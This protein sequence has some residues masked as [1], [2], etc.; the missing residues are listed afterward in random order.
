MSISQEYSQW[1]VVNKNIEIIKKYCRTRR[2]SRRC[3]YEISNI[4]ERWIISTFN[5]MGTITKSNAVINTKAIDE[6]V[7]KKI[8]YRDQATKILIN[9]F[10]KPLED[11]KINSIE[12]KTKIE[13]DQISF[14]PTNKKYK[15]F[16]IKVSPK[17]IE[18]L[19]QYP[20]LKIIRM[21][22]RY[23]TMIG[24]GQQWSIP[25]A[26]YDYFYNE[27]NARNEGFASPLNS[28]LMGKKD[29]NFCSL[30]KDVD[31]PFGS[32][33][34]FFDTPLRGVW[35]INP[36]FIESLMIATVNHMLNNLEMANQGN[37]ELTIFYI[38][39]SWFDSEAYTKVHESKYTRDEETLLPGQYFYE[40]AK[41]ITAKFK[42][43]AFVLS[44]RDFK[45]KNVWNKMKLIRGGKPKYAYCT[46]VFGGP[47]Y[48]PGAL[49]LAHSI[50][51]TKTKYPIICMVTPDIEK[52]DKQKLA[53]V[54]DRVVEVNYLEFK[55]QQMKTEKQREY[56]GEWSSKAYT[57][58]QCLN[59]PFHKVIFLDSDLIIVNN[60]DHIFDYN[61]PAGVL[62]NPWVQGSKNDF[63]KGLS[64]GKPIPLDK[65][66]KSL[67]NS[68]SPSAHLVLLEPNRD[69]FKKL[70][71]MVKKMSP[72]GFRKSI[73]GLD[74]QSINYLYLIKKKT[75]TFLDYRYNYILW[76]IKKMHYRLN[77]R[78]LPKPF[79]IHFT[80]KP[81]PWEMKREEW[82]DLGIYWQIA[83]DLI[84]RY[85]TLKSAF[86]TE[87]KKTETKCPYCTTIQ[88]MLGEEA[89]V[90]Q[91][92]H[93]FIKNGIIICPRIIFKN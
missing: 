41:N 79:A 71:N 74:E 19:K 47:A 91:V 57:K 82:S 63:T 88:K 31:E 70:I 65:M 24:G 54:F 9:N 22:L 46:L 11:I 7:E 83:A 67:Y 76:H 45:F 10:I 16:F 43:S 32:I 26:Q 73:S 89:G 17:Q 14:T 92:N 36:P 38:M 21:A 3:E 44:S 5:K 6:F 80:L 27:H 87:Y 15:K 8:F 34:S 4:I 72:F 62:S 59:L 77:K 51:I 20:N 30:F 28:K 84:R 86:S 56:Y 49:T 66:K 53:L 35:V 75:W 60:I 55:S 85:P 78:I 81:K 37:Y 61:A 64:H 2:D 48:I 12:G 29:A 39:P 58:W 42:S 93:K 40:G 52:Q 18:K 68:A 13:K 33:G 25:Q 69:D 1:L 23:G 50:K 90:N